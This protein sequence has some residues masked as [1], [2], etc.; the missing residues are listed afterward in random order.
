MN[1]KDVKAEIHELIIKARI[2]TIENQKKYHYNITSNPNNPETQQ[3]KA[4][5]E[6]VD[7]VMEYLK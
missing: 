4:F 5:L 2:E 7:A 3:S 1:E 6:L